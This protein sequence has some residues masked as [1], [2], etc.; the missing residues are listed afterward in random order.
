MPNKILEK[1]YLAEN[2]VSMWIEARQI[3][4]KRQPGQFLIL[5]PGERSERIPLT[6]ADVRAKEGAVRLIVQVVGK[7]TRD[8]AA[9]EAGEY[10]RDVAGPLGHPT[11]IKHYGT[12]ACVGGGIGVAPLLPIARAM[13]EAGNYVVS[14]IGAR[15]KGLLILEE[16]MRAISDELLITTDDGSYV[17]HGL[18]TDVLRERL[19]GKPGI[20]FAVAIGPVPMMKAV[21][22][23]TREAG[24]AT[25]A[26][27]NTI[28]IDGTGMCGGCRVT[29]GGRVKYTCV[30]GPEFDAHEVDFDELQRRLNMYRDHE[31]HQLEACKI[32]LAVR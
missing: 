20:D 21:A 6:I 7:T 12:V 2:V 9:L 26:S 24:I 17:R 31:L 27:L 30:D 19:T 22:N 8:L 10:V 11:P 25:I 15:T 14:I 29:V 18:V 1:E 3:A 28:M 13:K 32:G 23:L 16:D 5:R 4:K